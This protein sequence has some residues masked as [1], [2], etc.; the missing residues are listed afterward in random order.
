MKDEDTKKNLELP[1][2]DYTG[3]II[4]CEYTTKS[5]SGYPYF[6]WTIEVD[7]YEG[8]TIQTITMTI[9]GKRWLLKQL[10]DACG[11]R[12]DDKDP[13][14]KYCFDKEDILNKKVGFRI[15]NKE[16]TFTGRDGEQRTATRSEVVKFM[17]ADE[18]INEIID[19]EQV[20]F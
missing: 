13:N 4:T 1:D 2:G 10:L 19:D 17:D 15:Q 7:K 8:K 18:V 14:V 6:R 12:A 3:T 9:K 16:N 5:Q 20:P 11:I